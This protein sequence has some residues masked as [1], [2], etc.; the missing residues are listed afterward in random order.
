MLGDRRIASPHPLQHELPPHH[1][2]RVNGRALHT[3]DAHVHRLLLQGQ[4]RLFGVD[5]PGRLAAQISLL[6]RTVAS[7]HL[8]PLRSPREDA[9]STL[10]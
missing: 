10:R 9:G 4:S 2:L 6:G 5:L 3:R 8:L 1:V 7:L